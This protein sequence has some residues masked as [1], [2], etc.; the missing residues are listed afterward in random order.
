[1][2]AVQCTCD[3]CGKRGRCAHDRPAPPGWSYLRVYEDA[4][5]NDPHAPVDAYLTTVCVCS[6]ACRTA[7]PWRRIKT[8]R[9]VVAKSI[10]RRRK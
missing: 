9:A 4:P 2:K 5:A 8:R 1:M 7:L 3:A 6:D 10:S